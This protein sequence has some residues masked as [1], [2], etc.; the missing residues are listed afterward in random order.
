MLS[1]I[2]LAAAAGSAFLAAPA[3]ADEAGK[4]RFVHEGYTYVYEVKPAK[5]GQLITGTRYPG[6]AAFQLNVHDG[7]VTGMSGGQKVAFNVSDARGAAA[8]ASAN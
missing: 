5:D 6:A 1:K 8:G 7:K 3:I 2:V 4:A